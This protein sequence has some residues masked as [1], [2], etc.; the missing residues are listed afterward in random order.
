MLM[1]IAGLDVAGFSDLFSTIGLTLSSSGVQSFAVESTLWTF[2]F[3][4]AG[5]LVAVI[6]SGAVG[7]GT[8]IYTKDKSFLMIPVV[9]GVFFYWISVIVSI[10]NHTKDYPIFG[11]VIAMMLVP[12]TVGF[13]KAS[14]DF[15]LGV[16]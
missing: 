9:T 10:V 5:L 11:L 16:D 14:V 12:H 6:T 13:I 2:I 8:F 15:F 3:G 7:I 1:A 4:T